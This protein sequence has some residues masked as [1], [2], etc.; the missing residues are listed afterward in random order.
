MSSVIWSVVNLRV[1]C[2][3]YSVDIWRVLCGYHLWSAAQHGEDI[4]ASTT[5]S[6]SSAVGP[7]QLL[8]ALVVS[9]SDKLTIYIWHPMPVLTCRVQSNCNN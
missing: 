9:V 5:G 8:F 3:L 6:Q 1:C 2:A 7:P 4:I